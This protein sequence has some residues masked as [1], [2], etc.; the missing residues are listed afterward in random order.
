MH[1]PGG[2]GALER[3]SIYLIRHGQTP[4]NARRVIQMPD[5]PLSERGIDQAERLARRLATGRIAGILSSDF[6]RARM[7]TECLRAATGVEVVHDAVLRERSF[8]ALRGTA[9]ADLTVDPFAADYAP[10]GGETWEAFHARIDLAWRRIRD[11]ADGTAGNLAVVT[12]GLVCASLALRHLE[13]PDA[14][15][16]PARFRNASLTIVDARPPH[17]VRLLDCT[18]H[19]EEEGGPVSGRAPV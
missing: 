13:L 17:R 9:Y 8:G 14:G 3:A 11:V 1:E 19:L 16:P 6:A 2:A 15:A 7:T 4:G 18:D 12:H 10:P 5:T